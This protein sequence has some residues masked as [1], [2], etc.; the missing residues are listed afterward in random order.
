MI[1]TVVKSVFLAILVF[2]SPGAAVSQVTGQ[3]I[4]G[5]G[6]VTSIDNVEEIVYRKESSGEGGW[7]GR[8]VRLFLEDPSEELWVRDGR[9]PED[10]FLIRRDES[11]NTVETRDRQGNVNKY[12]SPRG[13]GVSPTLDDLRS[14]PGTK[15]K[16]EY[17][18]GKGRSMTRECTLGGLEDR[19]IGAEAVAAVH[20]RC[21]SLRSDWTYPMVSEFSA[22]FING[23]LR[24]IDEKRCWTHKRASKTCGKAP[25]S[26]DGHAHFFVERIEYRN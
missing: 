20:W 10:G 23:M 18:D 13:N 12:P 6:T 1:H 25:G 16:T 8:I 22:I 11:G 2:A 15:W 3:S 21:V 4:D 7:S 14:G 5:L 19:T 17:R 9:K 24:A 26:Y